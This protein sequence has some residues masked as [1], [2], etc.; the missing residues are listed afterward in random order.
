MI[1]QVNKEIKVHGACIIST[2]NNIRWSLKVLDFALS[3]F[4]ETVVSMNFTGGKNLGIQLHRINYMFL[5]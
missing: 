3:T 1:G 4:G 2:R 5:G